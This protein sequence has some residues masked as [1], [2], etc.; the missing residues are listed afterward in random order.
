MIS[1]QPLTK[2]GHYLV[3]EHAM[4][5]IRGRFIKE[6]EILYTL[7]SPESRE[8]C[9]YQDRTIIYNDSTQISIIIDNTS[10][11]IVTVTETDDRKVRMT[12]RKRLLGSWGPQMVHYPP[13]QV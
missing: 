3:C 1:Q 6:N 9:S 13:I 2:I 4:R 5:R 8:Y 7:D 10:G 11:I 12:H